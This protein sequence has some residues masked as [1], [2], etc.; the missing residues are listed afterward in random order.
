[1]VRSASDWKWSGYR[2]IAGLTLKEAVSTTDWILSCFADR[3]KQAHDRYR[4]FVQDGKNQPSPW[5][6]LKNQIYPGDDEF[7]EEMQCK[8]DPAQSLDD[9][10]GLQKLA[11]PKPIEYCTRKYSDP[12]QAMAMA[13]LSK[14]YTLEA[15]GTAFGVSCA[16]VSR[17]VRGH[18]QPCQL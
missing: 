2:A 4:S 7:V 17:A 9:I 3:K 8:L 10:P 5:E 11:P 12:K 15:V 14:H 1:M 16:T 13:Y 18:E 6:N